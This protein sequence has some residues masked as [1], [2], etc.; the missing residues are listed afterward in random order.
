MYVELKDDTRR[1]KAIL[2]TDTNVIESNNNI[3][4]S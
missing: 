2:A 4:K 1:K 3:Q